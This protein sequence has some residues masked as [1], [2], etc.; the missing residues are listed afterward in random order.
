MCVSAEDAQEGR[1]SSACTVRAVA[2][3]LQQQRS[4]LPWLLL[5]NSL[6]FPVHHPFGECFKEQ[7][8]LIQSRHGI[9]FLTALDVFINVSLAL[10]LFDKNTGLG[11]I[12]FYM[13]TNK[14]HL[15]CPV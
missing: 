4:A 5:H 15:S 14:F 10:I 13:R 7:R 6:G 12:L 8:T 9:V 3:S 11:F 2:L 1:S